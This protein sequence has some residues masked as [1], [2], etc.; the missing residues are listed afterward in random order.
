MSHRRAKKIRQYI[1]GMIELDK[2]RAA[3]GLPTQTSQLTS[4]AFRRLYRRMKRA[5]RDETSSR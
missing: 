1:R 4:G 2:H 5:W 3:D